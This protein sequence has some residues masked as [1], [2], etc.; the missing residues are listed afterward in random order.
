MFIPSNL[1]KD[2]KGLQQEFG[3]FFC[4]ILVKSLLLGGGG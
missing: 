4:L 1:G 3:V 2:K